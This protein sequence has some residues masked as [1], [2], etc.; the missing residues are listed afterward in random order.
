[1]QYPHTPN[2]LPLTSGR[3]ARKS[4]KAPASLAIM[5]G[6][7]LPIIDINRLRASGSLNAVAI[8]NGSQSPC[9]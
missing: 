6:V 4:K 7:T 8:S 2:V 5:S 1:M 9:R 3:C